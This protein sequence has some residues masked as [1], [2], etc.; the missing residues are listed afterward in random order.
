[1][2]LHPQAF[3]GG[4]HFLELASAF[5]YTM[6][7]MNERSIPSLNKII[8]LVTAVLLLGGAA[9]IARTIPHLGFREAALC[10][11]LAAT[12]ALVAILPFLLEYKAATRWVELTRLEE[13]LAQIHK[14]EQLAQQIS[15]ATAQWQ[16]VQTAAGKTTHAATEIAGRM[17]E[18][19]KGFTEFMRK[20]ND[21]EKSALRLEVEKLRRAEGDWLQILV[22]ILD[23]IFALH[24][25]AV[26]SGNTELSEQISHFQNACRD[27][28]RRIG[29]TPFA[30]AAD[31]PFDEKRHKT[32]DSE[33]AVAGSTV[34]ET[35]APGFTFQGQPLRPALVKLQT[36]TAAKTA[37]VPATDNPAEPTLL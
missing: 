32:L 19:L 37:A 33:K 20:A 11:G 35:L 30:A 17:D 31:E 4:S 13:T 16:E 5:R 22:R 15:R 36:A 2:D 3:R 25:A 8:F 12:A 10:A 9:F 34:A 26:R 14:L 27:V 1:M 23:H 6:L 29:L 7:R 24:Q 18:E 21:S 28:A